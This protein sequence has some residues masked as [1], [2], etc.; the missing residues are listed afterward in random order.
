[1]PAVIG[2]SSRWFGTMVRGAYNMRD[3]VLILTS[4]A[5]SPHVGND[6]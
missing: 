5:Y 1:M 4:L 3:D 6:V 2:W